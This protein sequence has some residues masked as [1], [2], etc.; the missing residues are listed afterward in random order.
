VWPYD[1]TC[2]PKDANGCVDFVAKN[3]GAFEDS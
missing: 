1:A 2:A 3:P